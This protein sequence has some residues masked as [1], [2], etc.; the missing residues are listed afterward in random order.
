MDGAPVTDTPPGVEVPL[1]LTLTEH[2]ESVRRVVVPE[3]RLIATACADGCVRIFSQD[4]DGRPIHCLATHGVGPGMSGVGSPAP[5]L[6]GVGGLAPLGD[7]VIASGGAHDRRI[8]TWLASSGALLESLE[9]PDRCVEVS[10]LA[11]AGSG[12][13]CLVAG[14]FSGDL[15]FVSHSKGHKL[16]V[17][18]SEP[19]AC[20]VIDSITVD[21]DL[22]VVGGRES[23]N[24][25]SVAT[26]KRIA[27]LVGH[28]SWVPS[29]SVAVSRRYIATSSIQQAVFLYSNVAGYPIVGTLPEI[30]DNVRRNVDHV[31]LVGDALLV[32]AFASE[33]IFGNRRGTRL[34]FRSLPAC[35]VL[36]HMDV[37]IGRINSFAITADGRLAC[38]GNGGPMALIIN[39]PARVAA[40]IKDY[41]ALLFAP[42]STKSVM[43]FMVTRSLGASASLK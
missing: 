24:I 38:V 25:F 30:L 33:D 40:A 41:A 26:R 7:D 42:F 17:V 35:E 14:T 21:G 8:S 37:D 34:C 22:I 20:G 39:P 12:G 1:P 3:S 16:H 32:S 27:V 43:S 29:A 36:A 6:N 4:G 31:T 2:V 23:V 13:G 15:F 9:L 11:V 19:S 5:L 18:A 10:A 28:T